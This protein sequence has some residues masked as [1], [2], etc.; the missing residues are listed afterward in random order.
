MSSCLVIIPFI[1]QLTQNWDSPKC[2]DSIS[3]GRTEHHQ[4]CLFLREDSKQSPWV[5]LSLYLDSQEVIDI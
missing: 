5:L 4:N 1:T 3:E 2:S